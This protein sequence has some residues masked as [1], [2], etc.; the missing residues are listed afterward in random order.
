MFIF[1][2]FI[3]TLTSQNQ[4]I[5]IQLPKLRKSLEVEFKKMK[6]VFFAVLFITLKKK[7][8]SAELF[9]EVNSLMDNSNL[10]D[11]EQSLKEELLF[12][13][14][15][16]TELDSADENR[17]KK[18]FVK[19]DNS[20]NDTSSDDILSNVNSTDGTRSSNN[21]IYDNWSNDTLTDDNWSNDTLTDDNWSNDNLT[22]D[23]WSN[24]TSIFEDSL[25]A[26]NLTEIGI[27]F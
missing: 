12:T 26:P 2:L 8:T 5:N 7:T 3:Y 19:N 27:C 13:V 6:C 9:A 10:S 20:L 18:S 14:T 22:D 15:E 25:F 17:N 11:S 16:T 23:N 21:L 24:D 4:I 1:K